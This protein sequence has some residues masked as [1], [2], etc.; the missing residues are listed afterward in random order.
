M[1]LSFFGDI[2]CYLEFQQ[3]LKAVLDSGRRLSFPDG[4]LINGRG[5]TGASFTVEKGLFNLSFPSDDLVR[6]I[7]VPRP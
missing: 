2:S 1:S 3:V 4:M 6:I 5:P 7:K